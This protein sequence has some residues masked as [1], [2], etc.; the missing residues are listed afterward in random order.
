M[1]AV[2][3][4]SVGALVRDV[5]RAEV[6]PRFRALRPADVVSKATAADPDDVVTVADLA[7]E[8]RLAP[9]LAALVPGSIVVAEEAV[10]A[11]AS[12]LNAVRGDAPV[13]LVDPLDGTRNFAAGRE[14]FGTMVALAAAGDVRAGWIYLPTR[15]ELFAAE[16]GAGAW[17]NGA[18]LHAPASPPTGRARGTLYTRHMPAALRDA[19]AARAHLY[20][21]VAG[22]G[23]ACCEYTAVARGE[24]DF[25]VY[26][27]LHPWDHAPGALLVREAGGEAAHP[28]G[29]PYRVRDAN[30]PTLVTRAASWFPELARA[31]FG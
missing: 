22:P 5:C 20:E 21:E 30:Q 12:L 4:D 1:Q 18:R 11:D 29:A 9:A 3:V 10:A 6:L 23:S 31:L 15:D 25:V 7:V 28:G 14:D 16:A 27:R 13:W 2:D 19:L 8:R 26:H 24:K 17:C